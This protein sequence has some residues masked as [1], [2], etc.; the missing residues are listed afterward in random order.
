ME[1]VKLV[2]VG[3]AGVGK[4]TFLQRLR[5]PE[6]KTLSGVIAPTLGVD[7]VIITL[8]VD[9]A[10]KVQLYL[11]DMAGQE[12]FDTIVGSYLRDQDGVIFVFDVSD[13]RSAMAITE[14]WVP[15]VARHLR[16]LEEK[17]ADAAESTDCEL[18]AQT[19]SLL[20][21]NKSDLEPP[22]VDLEAMSEIASA[23]GMTFLTVSALQSS[24]EELSQPVSWLVTEIIRERK[25]L[26]KLTSA[27]DRSDVVCLG[28]T[29]GIPIDGVDVTTVG[30]G[31]NGCCS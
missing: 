20:I 25:R 24:V 30:R 22:V 13:R 9:H 18:I 10:I 8:V 26:G 5:F 29:R 31:G 1:K 6:E 15:R 27:S 7:F 4:S 21:A 11:W 12:R 3:N 19:H 14:R 23:H 16:D 17:D 28:G 2:V